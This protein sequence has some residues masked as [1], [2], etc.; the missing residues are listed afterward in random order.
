MS[1]TPYKNDELRTFIANR[2]IDTS[3]VIVKGKKG[4]RKELLEL[5]DQADQNP[6][7]EKFTSLPAEIR[8]RIYTMY[9]AEFPEP[10]YAPIQPPLTLTCRQLRGET[11]QMFYHTIQLAIAFVQQNNPDYVR[12]QY[13]VRLHIPSEQLLWLHSL[14][15]ARASS[16]RRLR[17]DIKHDDTGRRWWRDD[18]NFGAG[19]LGWFELDIVALGGDRKT[20]LVLRF[21]EGPSQYVRHKLERTRRFIMRAVVKIN[22]RKGA[23]GF[24]VEDLKA[25]RNAMEA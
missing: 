1:Y 3:T 10:I 14:S 15:P 11:L 9:F 18:P 7:F 2:G 24:T 6:R 5:L 12:P 8:H 25:L 19:G 22:A 21:P 23:G 17:I 4:T 13:H 16:L 20:R